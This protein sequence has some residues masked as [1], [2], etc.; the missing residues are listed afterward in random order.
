LLDHGSAGVQCASMSEKI[1]LMMQHIKKY[2]KDTK[3]TRSMVE[4]I[5]KRRNMLDYLMRTDYHRYKWICVDYG[6]PESASKNSIHK[7]DFQLF[8]NPSRGL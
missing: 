5:Q 1:I 3:A 2:P 8:I 6:I 7:T 4:L